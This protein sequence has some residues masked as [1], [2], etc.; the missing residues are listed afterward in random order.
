[1]VAPMK[2]YTIA[3][4]SKQLG[5][6]EARIKQLVIELRLVPERGPRRAYKFLQ[7]HI[8]AMRARNKKPGPNQND[9]KPKVRR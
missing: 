2:E 6:S 9:S 7:Y 5:I 8:A 3:Q 1:M 4:V